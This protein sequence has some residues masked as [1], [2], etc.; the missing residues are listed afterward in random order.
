MLKLGIPIGMLYPDQLNCMVQPYALY[1]Y[2]RTKP[3][4]LL[5]SLLLNNTW[6]AHGLC[7]FFFDDV[8]PLQ[9]KVVWT[10]IWKVN[11][12]YLHLPAIQRYHL[13]LGVVIES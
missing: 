2:L 10:H 11:P 5:C 13:S 1:G 12:E 6:K 3:S 9:G 7:H 4:I 8:E